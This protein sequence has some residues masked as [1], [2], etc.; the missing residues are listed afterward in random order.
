[1]FMCALQVC[2]VSPIFLFRHI[3]SPTVGFTTTTTKPA[4]SIFEVSDYRALIRA[5]QMLFSNFEKC[6]FKYLF[7][8]NYKIKKSTFSETFVSAYEQVIQNDCSVLHKARLSETLI[9]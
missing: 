8:L 5:F 9:N 7:G 2:F 3:A 6:I 4:M 1:M